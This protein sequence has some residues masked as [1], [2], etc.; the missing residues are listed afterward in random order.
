VYE[1]N[2]ACASRKCHLDT[3]GFDSLIVLITFRQEVKVVQPG[4][5]VYRINK[6]WF[7]SFFVYRR[8]WTVLE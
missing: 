3:F 5:I 8:H 6:I 1:L 2:H 7:V 4:I